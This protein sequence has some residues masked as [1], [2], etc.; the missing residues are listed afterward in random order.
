MF[1]ATI[2]DAGVDS[3]SREAVVAQDADAATSTPSMANQ[4]AA[5]LWPAVELFNCALKA[6]L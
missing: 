1:A 5:K 3:F 4:I 2:P 6:K